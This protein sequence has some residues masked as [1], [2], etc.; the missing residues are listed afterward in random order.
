[1]ISSGM[2][3][4]CRKAHTRNRSAAAAERSSHLGKRERPGGCHRLGMIEHQS[5]TRLEQ[6]GTLAAVELQVIGQATLCFLDVGSSLVQ[7]QGQSSQ[8]LGDLEGDGTLTRLGLLQWCIGGQPIGKA[9]QEQSTWFAVQGIDLD[10][11]CQSAHAGSTRG[12]QACALCPQVA[13]S[14]AQA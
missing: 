5:S 6:V 2:A 9:Q 11:V 14:P 1:M 7:R 3:S 4:G 10:G 8:F 12:E 13:E